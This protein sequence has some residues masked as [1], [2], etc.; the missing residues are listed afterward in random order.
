[1]FFLVMTTDRLRELRAMP[2][3][4][5]LATSEWRTRRDRAL[6]RGGWRCALC[7]AK[8]RLQVHHN[9][10]DNIGDERDEDLTVLCDDCHERHHLSDRFDRELRVYLLA[11]R[12]RIYKRTFASTSDVAEDLKQTYA[13][14]HL[15]YDAELIT[16]VLARLKPEIDE[17][18][19]EVQVY[20]FSP[21]SYVHITRHGSAPQVVSA[22]EAAYRRLK[23]FPSPHAFAPTDETYNQTVRMAQALIGQPDARKR[24]AQIFESSKQRDTDLA[25]RVADIMEIDHY[26]RRFR[27]A[28]DHTSGD[29]Q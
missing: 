28:D 23:T 24:L 21:R 7:A 8:N 15:P 16:Q 4:E 19:A 26:I 2:Y 10:Y 20:L 25:K 11:A 3:E 17:R 1:M 9:C 27:E 14:L 6:S 18:R 12:S 13:E 5:Y 29:G 22:I